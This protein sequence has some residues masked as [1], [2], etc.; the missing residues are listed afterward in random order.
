VDAQKT[1]HKAVNVIA[2]HFAYVED[3]PENGNMHDSFH[4]NMKNKE[5]SMSRGSPL[6]ATVLSFST[7]ARRIRHIGFW[8]ILFILLSPMTVSI[9]ADEV[10][11]TVINKTDY[12]LH[13]IINGNPYLYVSPEGF[14]L[15]QSEGPLHT[16]VKAFYSPGQGVSG[17]ATESFDLRVG[18]GGHS[19]YQ[20]TKGE[21]R[22]SSEPSYGPSAEVWE[23]TPDLL[24]ND[25]LSQTSW[26]VGEAGT[27][28]KTSDGGRNWGGQSSGSSSFLFDVFCADLQTVWVVGSQG[29]ILKTTDGGTMWFGQISGTI[30][31][32]SSVYFADLQKGWA[33]GENGTI[34]NTTNSG[35][36]WSIQTT[37]TTNQLSGVHFVD[38]STGWVVGIGGTIMKTT[39]GGSDPN[40]W[41]S[42]P[43]G[44]TNDL[45]SVYFLDSETGWASGSNGTIVRTTDGGTTWTVL[46]SGTTEHLDGIFFTDL[47]TG[48]AVGGSG[49]VQK[50]I[51]GG[52]TW[53]SQDLG[54]PW[55]RSVYF[56][57]SETGWAVAGLGVIARTT[58]GGNTWTAQQSGTTR[59]LRS[60]MAAK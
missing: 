45:R 54:D 25:T 27:I 39:T 50:T 11:V 9:G 10:S 20:D 8:I 56:T 16:T 12:Y 18:G 58:N 2:I 51:N 37:G 7:T 15:Y 60:V 22:C 43:S 19:C 41:F 55:L 40:G 47:H 32:L 44:T 26:V 36:T 48:W 4:L 3:S 14:A 24:R 34:V 1:S 17:S 59:N 33:V 42:Q 52:T 21:C 28:L 29:T 5:A 23:V 35:N 30:L 53:F 38:A 31:N 57:D 49:T 13:V 6:I 46:T